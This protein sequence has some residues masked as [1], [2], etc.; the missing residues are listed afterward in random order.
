MGG[1]AST[2]HQARY[3]KVGAERPPLVSLSGPYLV[4]LW[5]DSWLHA[6]ITEGFEGLSIELSLTAYEA[7]SLHQPSH[8]SPRSPQSVS[9]AGSQPSRLCLVCCF[10]IVSISGDKD[11][12]QGQLSPGGARLLPWRR[13]R[14]TVTKGRLEDSVSW[15]L[16]LSL[17]L[18]V[19]LSFCLSLPTSFSARLLGSFLMGNKSHLLGPPWPP[20]H[21]I[22]KL[23]PSII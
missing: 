22:L 17:Y 4:V 8:S 5:A 20:V 10:V 1:A 16:C 3:Q 15:S 12:C 2:E 9:S 19:P 18:S 23:Y 11:L 14:F 7:N 13:S 6:Q 21:T